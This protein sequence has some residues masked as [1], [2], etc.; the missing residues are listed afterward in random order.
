M[1]P[2]TENDGTSPRADLW[3]GIVWIVVGLAIFWGSWTMDRLPH[4]HIQFYTVPG[5]LPG[6]LGIIIALMGA[7]LLG[8][9][10]RA[11]A[12]QSVMPRRFVA[13]DHWRLAFTLGW[14]VF[15]AA[16]VIASLIP[17]WLSTA[18]YVAV[19][20]IVFQYEER[21]ARGQLPRGFLVALVHGLLSG[22]IIHYVFEDLFLV[23]LP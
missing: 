23:R 5:L 17:F 3:G 22:L 16:I 21:R 20:V 8:R 14:S 15:Y 4:F 10:I 9:A 18:A 11:G 6:I 7:I 13:A 19:F 2:A 1:E 12:L